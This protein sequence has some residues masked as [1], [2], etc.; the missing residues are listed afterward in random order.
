MCLEYDM[1]TN[2]STKNINRLCVGEAGERPYNFYIPAYQRGYRWEEHVE[3]LLNDIFEFSASGNNNVGDY[4]CLQPIIIKRRKELDDNDISYEVI[5]G[6]QRL[7][8]IYILLKALGHT[9]DWFKITYERDN[10]SK[11]RENFLLNLKE[12]TKTTFE[13]A[14]FHFIQN[15]YRLTK[16]WI[17][18]KKEK[19]NENPSRRMLTTLLDEV[20]VIWYEPDDPTQEKKAFARE[21]FRNINAGKI[22]LTS[23]ELIKAMMLNEKF[24]KE[25]IQ[26]TR[27]GSTELLD[28]NELKN[29]NAMIRIQQDRIAILWD[30]IERTLQQKDFWGFIYHNEFEFSTRIDY[31]FRLI[32]QQDTQK[33]IKNEQDILDYF[34]ENLRDHN[35]VEKIWEEKVRK[36]YRTFQDWFSDEQLY[37]YIGYTINH[38]LRDGILDIYNKYNTVDK[39]SFE[40]YLIEQIQNNLYITENRFFDLN[41]NDHKR[42]I[43]K[44][45]MLFNIE[46]MNLKKQK[47]VFDVPG[48]WSVEHVFA[49][50]SPKIPPKEREAW[51]Q[52]YLAVVDSAILFSAGQEERLDKL[53]ALK[54]DIKNF[55]SSEDAAFTPLFENIIRLVEQYGFVGASDS[56]E[57]IDEN[58]K[59]DID[60]IANL[61]LIGKDDNAA[62]SNDIFYG[63]RQKIIERVEGGRNIPQGTINLFMKWYSGEKTN[64]D[65]WGPSDGR[66]YLERM[67]NLIQ[68]FF[69]LDGLHEQ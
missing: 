19:S 59:L 45:L 42:I 6:Q 57:V 53:N 12:S 35:S 31:I 68:H 64:L 38:R 66:M 58:N 22:P 15:A 36:L 17:K 30:E 23:A 65:F 3:R 16:N 29:Q 46:I 10:Q 51:L 43:L 14:D 62:L 34:E 52:Q 40:K 1:L 47:F 32:Y 7:T 26:S 69:I 20:I 48:G 54:S 41:Y 24:Y 55:K 44:I 5:D 28:D 8:T 63:K 9:D 33:A 49:V 67:K 2:L 18:N 4:Y 21:T 37:N 11:D 39:P 61:S 60:N 25:K 27:K 56:T 13:K 50:R